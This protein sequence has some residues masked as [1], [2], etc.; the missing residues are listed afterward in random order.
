MYVSGE[1]ATGD[2]EGEVAMATLWALLGWCSGRD[3][4]LAFVGLGPLELRADRL[5]RTVVAIPR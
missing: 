1:I 2:I 3:V 4:G 5:R